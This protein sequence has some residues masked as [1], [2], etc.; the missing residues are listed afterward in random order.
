MKIWVSYINWKYNIYFF[1][2]LS[3]CSENTLMYHEKVME[4]SHILSFLKVL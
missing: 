1:I 4:K 3:H 2:V